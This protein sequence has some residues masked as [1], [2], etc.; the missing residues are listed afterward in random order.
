M[1]W[2]RRSK[3]VFAPYKLIAVD[4]MPSLCWE[5]T[6][7]YLDLRRLHIRAPMVTLYSEDPATAERHKDAAA[8]FLHVD[9]MRRGSSPRLMC[10]YFWRLLDLSGR[11]DIPRE[12]IDTIHQRGFLLAHDCPQGWGALSVIGWG[13]LS[14]NRYRS[15]SIECFRQAARPQLARQLLSPVPPCPFTL[16]AAAADSVRIV[17]TSGSGASH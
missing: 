1:A 15:L 17:L 12:L 5:W 2:L 9:A 8:A 13:S 10:R 7:Q 3:L 6:L 14:A 11:W 4:W 16:R